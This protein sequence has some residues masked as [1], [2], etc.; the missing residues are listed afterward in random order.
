MSTKCMICRQPSTD[1]VCNPCQ[2][3]EMIPCDTC[4]TLIPT[5]KRNGKPFKHPRC[6]PCTTRSFAHTRRIGVKCRVCGNR[7]PDTA[8]QYQV[9]KSCQFITTICPVCLSS[10]PAYKKRGK[11]RT[12]CSNSCSGKKRPSPNTIAKTIAGRKATYDLKGRRSAENKRLRRSKHYLNWRT[13]VFK[14]DG[15]TCQDC[16]Q[17]GGT[18]HPHH[19]MPFATHKHL[20]FEISNGITLC[21]DCHRK[22]H[23]H[24]FIGRVRKLKS[25]PG[26]VQLHLPTFEE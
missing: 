5:I 17:R 13:S 2:L 18:L 4:N 14:R 11:P 21:V 24:I 15:Y 25:V 1:A 9:C 23:N 6:S 8:E 26:V 7:A 22:R 19:I 12:S 16:Q 3:K 10:M 20:R